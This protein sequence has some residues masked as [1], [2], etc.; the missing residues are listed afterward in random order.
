MI[1]FFNCVFIF[2]LAFD[3]Q[4]AKTTWK[5][6]ISLGIT[7][8]T[9]K[10]GAFPSSSNISLYF[11]FR[12]ICKCQDIY[13]SPYSVYATPQNAW[14]EKVF[15][16]KVTNLRTQI[17]LKYLSQLS[18]HFSW[19]FLWIFLWIVT[20]NADVNCILFHA[21]ARAISPPMDLAHAKFL[22]SMNLT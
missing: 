21:M 20:A 14:N 11:F 13:F 2:D 19:I 22:L 15:S 12:C 17:H 18:L 8:T 9:S 7:T 1:S 4:I 3:I 6:Q 5:C 16:A 10:L